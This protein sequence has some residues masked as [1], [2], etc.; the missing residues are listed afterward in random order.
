MSG[1]RAITRTNGDELRDPCYVNAMSHFYRGELGRIMVWR[2]RLDITTTWAITSTTTI[3]TVAFSF[4]DI[5]HIIFF[6]NLVI[7]WMMLW[8]EARRYRFYD[9]FRGR[10][11]MIESHFLVATV[12]RNPSLL[13]GDWQKLVCE[14]LILPSFKIS[15]LEAVGRRLKRNYV[16]IIAIIIVAW[17]TKIFMHASPAIHSWSAFYK[18]LAVGELPGW[19]VGAVLVVTVITTTA[20]TWYVSVNSSGEVTDLRG[21]HKEQWRI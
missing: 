4:R 14:D 18:A 5:P 13:G 6:F 10:V 16:F 8:I 20:L 7:V 9:A 1:D 2:Q 3:I 11:R 17:M 21:S 12:S 15:K 19:L